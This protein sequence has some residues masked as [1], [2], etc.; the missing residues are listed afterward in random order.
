M[1]MINDDD[2]VQAQYKAMLDILGIRIHAIIPR[3]NI[4]RYLK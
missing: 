3:K 1:M 2:Y 4:K